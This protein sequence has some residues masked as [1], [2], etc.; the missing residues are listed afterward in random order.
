MYASGT[1][2]GHSLSHCA[3]ALISNVSPLSSG[4]SYSSVIPSLHTALMDCRDI[5][6]AFFLLIHPYTLLD[7][8][9]YFYSIWAKPCTGQKSSRAL[10]RAAMPPV[11]RQSACRN[12]RSSLFLVFR[13]PI[14][15]LSLGPIHTTYL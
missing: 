8:Q 14:K 4:A 10:C 12:V 7:L 9:R 11:R 6:S 3:L 15:F 2:T 5:L 1:P 13:L